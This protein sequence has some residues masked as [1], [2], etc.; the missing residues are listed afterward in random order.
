[1]YKNEYIPNLDLSDFDMYFNRVNISD[2]DFSYFVF[3]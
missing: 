3:H 2:L 1:M